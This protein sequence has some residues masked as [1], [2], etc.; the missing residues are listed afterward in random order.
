M[1]FSDSLNQFLRYLKTEKN[2]S[3]HTISSYRLD[4][5]QFRDCIL[6]HTPSAAI[7]S[8]NITLAEARKFLLW[9]TRKGLARTSIL[10]KISALRSFC[11]FLIRE[12]ILENNPFSILNTPRRPRSLPHV[13]SEQEVNKVLNAPSKY[14]QKVKNLKGN[15]STSFA[16]FAGKRD[17]A[18]LEVLYSAGLRISEVINL[19]YEDIDFYSKSFKIRGKGK[20]ER[21]GI[22]GTPA[23]TAIKDYLGLRDA[24]G[25]GK[26]HDR[27]ALFVNKLGTPI[28]A[29]SVQRSFKWYL[30]EA[31]L[32]F[33]LTP[34][35]LRHS[36]ATHLLNAGA[37]LR[38]VQEMLGHSS[39][40]TTQIY[41]HVSPEHL[42]SVYAKTHPRATF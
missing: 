20:K 36:F 35:A 14:W 18:I 3:E 22:L 7:N 2:A 29:R 1:L 27:G 11:R 8:T 33:D 5:C 24:L 15:S 37:D 26:K 38:S 9:L 19:R 25:L 40:S 21:Y 30:E 32:P 31:G 16:A 10:R 28:S 6:D 39:L 17:Q 42:I 12:E 41:T 13:F 34:H 23:V 4:I